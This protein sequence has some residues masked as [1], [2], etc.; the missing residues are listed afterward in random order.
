MHALLTCRFF[1]AALLFGMVSAAAAAAH[2]GKCAPTD[3]PYHSWT[4]WAI[5][6]FLAQKKSPEV[7][8]LGSSLMLVP[9]AGLDADYMNRKLDGSAHHASVYFENELART[10]GTK[11]SAFNFALPGEMPSDAYLITKFLL[12]GAHRPDVIIYGVGPRDFMD[13]LLQNPAA[14]DPYQFLSRFGD[15][16]PLVSRTMPG[17]FERFNYELGQLNY[18]Y[19]NRIDIC[20][21]FESE[22]GAALKEVLPAK[23]EMS[24]EAVHAMLPTYKPF[25]LEREEA[26]FRPPTEAELANFVDNLSE[27]RQRYKKLK[28]DTFLT[29][30]HFMQ[31][32]LKTARERGT[33]VVVVSMPITDVNR[34]LISDSAW[35]LYRN[36]LH[37]VATATG[38]SFID[39][40][41]SACFNR[42]DFCD[43]VHLHARGG[44]KFLDLLT[45]QLVDNQRVKTALRV[46]PK[47]TTIAGKAR[48]SL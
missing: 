14:T 40:S 34:E 30:L 28:W 6:D 10:T 12:K 4:S 44:R 19:G 35:N 23:K 7:V 8:F 25:Q 16:S 36:S 9:M 1:V 3:Y 47:E 33:H 37:A 15:V 13:N 27:Y 45:E 41:E 29:Q 11:L 46:A 21:S 26:F 38:A 2:L 5:D 24:R 43:T 17:F 32:T 18:F 39:F 48:T 22:V 42:K 20:H 31:E